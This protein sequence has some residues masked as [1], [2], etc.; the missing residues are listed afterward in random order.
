MTVVTDHLETL[1][2]PWDWRDLATEP[3]EVTELKVRRANELGA[4]AVIYT[5]DQTA[6]R[7]LELAM[8]E[9][10]WITSSEI[11]HQYG[12][13]L[14]GGVPVAGPLFLDIAALA[15]PVHPDVAYFKATRYGHSQVGGS[16]IEIDQP[17]GKSTDIGG[18]RFKIVDDTIDEGLT[19]EGAA[20]MALDPARAKK[21]G[22]GITEPAAEVHVLALADKGFAQL[23]SIDP[24]HITR[25]MYV[26]DVWMGGRGLDGPG[27]TF[28]WGNEL[29]I[30][31]IQHVKYRDT[32]AKVL[33]VLGDRA[34]R[35]M[36]EITWID[37]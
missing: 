26:P 2:T 33:Y 16:N 9:R 12:V 4:V 18:K 34:V 29:V 28:R 11:P 7:L 23:D 17:F 5:A 35:T 24:A 3:P 32:M 6:Q 27:E 30:T 8:L 36:D 19:L 15:D 14:N 1:R 10:A 21:L 25:G 31:S 13:I 20:A 22:R 37:D